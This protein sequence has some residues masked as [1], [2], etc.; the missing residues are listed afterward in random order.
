ME[1]VD[2]KSH[3]QADI[4]EYH[5]KMS[6]KILGVDLSV[7][8]TPHAP[9]AGLTYEKVKRMMDKFTPKRITIGGEE[10]NV[11]GYYVHDWDGW[12]VLS[13]MWDE[14]EL[15]HK[16]TPLGCGGVIFINH[17]EGKLIG[18]EEDLKRLA[19]NCEPVYIEGKKQ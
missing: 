12:T 3:I 16:S 11:Y 10:F 1:N 17:S 13:R 2:I 8:A 15:L 19:Q 9:S 7:A 6:E 18:C 14:D 5:R 4:D